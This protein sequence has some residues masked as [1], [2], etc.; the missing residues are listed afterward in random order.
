MCKN[1]F[2]LLFI[3]LAA[4]GFLYA[5]NPIYPT[6]MPAVSFLQYVPFALTFLGWTFWVAFILKLG[7]DDN[8]EH[9]GSWAERTFP[10]WET[11]QD[12]ESQ[13]V[14]TVAP[15]SVKPG[16]KDKSSDTPTHHAA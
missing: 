16:P 15:I 7:S 13:P 12:G 3:F 10:G 9:H 1:S 8:K 14:R 4:T 5:D 2:Y 11:T 6:G